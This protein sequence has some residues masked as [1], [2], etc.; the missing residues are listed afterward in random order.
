MRVLVV[1]DE[2]KGGTRAVVEAQ[3]AWLQQHAE[4]RVEMAR[5]APLATA[6]IDLVVVFGGDGSILAAVRRMGDQ[7]RPTLGFNLGRLGFLTAFGADK[8]RHG[9]ELAL[10]GKLHE[11]RRLLLSCWIER[12]DGSR[13]DPV[14]ALNDGVLQRSAS[15]TIVTIQALRGTKELAAYAGDGLIVATPVGSTAYSLA[16]GGPILAPD[17]EAL[18]LTP[19]ASH[20]LTVRPL[21]IPADGGVD[22]MVEEAGGEESCSFVVDGQLPMQVRIGDRVV[23]RP[24]AARYRGLTRAR[25]AFF[26]VL[27]DKLGWADLPRQRAQRRPRR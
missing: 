24:A 19:L 5:D 12:Q 23:L 15:A 27:R 16:A 1:G 13:T 10:A 21:V 26:E 22:L 6:D 3:V 20:T 17:L 2:R 7:Q 8:V 18:V 11:E 14:L 9:L 25:G 4:V